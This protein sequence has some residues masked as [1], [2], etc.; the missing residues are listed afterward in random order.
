MSNEEKSSVGID[1]M[2]DWARR[3]PPPNGPVPDGDLA[4]HLGAQRLVV[5]LMDDR[6]RAYHLNNVNLVGANIARFEQ[7]RSAI[8]ELMDSLGVQDGPN[9][10]NIGD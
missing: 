10:S 3:A 1:Q 9:W 4:S 6:G 5:V 2:K 8:N 7:P